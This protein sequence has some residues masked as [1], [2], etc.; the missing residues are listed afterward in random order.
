MNGEELNSAEKDSMSLLDSLIE[1]IQSDNIEYSTSTHNSEPLETYNK[2]TYAGSKT[3]ELVVF[4]TSVEQ[5][6]KIIKTVNELND[7]GGSYTI[8]TVSSGQNWGYGSATPTCDNVILL[9]LKKMNKQPEWVGNQHDQN[10]PYGKTLGIV[11][12]EP[13]VSQIQLYEFLQSEGGKFW[14]DA[15]GS[16]IHCSV[17]ANYM[18]R[19]F[20]HT[21]YGD[22]FDHVAG[23]EAVMADGTFVKTGHAGCNNAANVGVH[24][25]GVGPVLE[26]LASQSN[27]FIVTAIY[28]H[29]MPAKKKLWKYFIKMNSDQVFYETVEQLRPLKLNGTLNSQMHCA[30]S[31]KGIQA[32]MR[33]P[34]KETNGQVPMSDELV[35]RLAA[36]NQISPWTISGALYGDSFWELFYKFLAVRKQL[37]GKGKSM[38][39]LPSWLAKFFKRVFSSNTMAK[40]LPKLQQ[41]MLPQ[42]TVLNELIGLKQGKPTNF[43]VDSVYHRKRDIAGMTGNPDVDQVGLIW[44][45]PLGPMTRESLQL[46]IEHSTAISGKYKFDPAISITLLNERAV[47]CVLSIVFDRSDEEEDQ[48]A[49][50]CYDELMEGFNKLGFTSYR[51]SA[52][53]MINDQLNYGPELKHLHRTLK[54]GLDPKNILSPNHYLN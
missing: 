26:G 22:H 5:I 42:F 9:C 43:F 40:L 35:E 32:V 11:R 48:N 13:G 6:Q 46:L 52:R 19:G 31:H 39:M 8:Y 21:F 28:I 16:S 23:I 24:K 37:K 34:F 30:N 33:Y 45:A 2:C 10:G 41:K 50:A 14:M 25:H 29:L 54:Q 27:L 3:S 18:E 7:Q 53:A 1:T 17:L 38:L 20:G 36:E 4:P 12:I 49:V 15:T 44:I 51:S 47:D